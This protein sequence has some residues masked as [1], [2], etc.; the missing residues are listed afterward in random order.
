MKPESAKALTWSAAI[1]ILLGLIVMSPSAAFGSFVLAALCAFFPAAFG[2]KKTRIFAALLLIASLAL[3]VAYFSE[4][5]REQNAY[6]QRA[7]AP[8]A[9]PAVPQTQEPKK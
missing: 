5:Q 6:R 9:S 1:L 3:S 4:F 2:A 7:K 8:A